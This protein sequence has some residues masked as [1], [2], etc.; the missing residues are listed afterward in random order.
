MTASGGRRSSRDVQRLLLGASDFCGPHFVEALRRD[1]QPGMRPSSRLRALGMCAGTWDLT[2]EVAERVLAPEAKVH[3][4][5]DGARVELAPSRPAVDGKPWW[6]PFV[7]ALERCEAGHPETE[8]A[9]LLAGEINL[10][11]EA[12]L[13]RDEAAYRRVEDEYSGPGPMGDDDELEEWVL[14]NPDQA[15]DLLAD[16]R[17][18]L[19]GVA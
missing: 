9:R 19:A 15:G 5:E 7:E 8:E 3:V 17:A 10:V 6:R 18:A 12:L 1:F 16:L 4:G 13:E 2:C 14:E 11:A